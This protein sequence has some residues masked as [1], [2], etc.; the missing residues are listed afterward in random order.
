M[1]CSGVF[2]VLFKFQY[3]VS[4]QPKMNKNLY[5]CIQHWAAVTEE[6]AMA[7]RSSVLA[8][9]ALDRGAWWAAVSG[10]AESRTGLKR[11]SSSSSSD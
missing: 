5:R 7:T 10:V 8:G 6:K 4:D 9:E 11:L 2:G 3:F 1:A